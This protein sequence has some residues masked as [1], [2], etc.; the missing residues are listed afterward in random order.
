[1]RKSGVAESFEP[2]MRRKPE[3]NGDLILTSGEG[4]TE[5][6]SSSILGKYTGPGWEKRVDDLTF[7]EW[8]EDGR[9]FGSGYRKVLVAL[10][11]WLA[12]GGRRWGKTYDYAEHLTGLSQGRLKDIGAVDRMIP[13]GKVVFHDKLTFAHHEAVVDEKSNLSDAERLELT[14][15]AERE[16]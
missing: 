16:D 2:G 10:A 8:E 4:M 15:R 13:G 7:E 6:N 5:K 9:Q 12:T 1:M 11:R 3:V 14:D